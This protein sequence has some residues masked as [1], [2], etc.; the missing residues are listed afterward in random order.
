[1]ISIGEE[2]LQ[3]ILAENIRLKAQIDELQAASTAQLMRDRGNDRR[4]MVSAFHLKFNQPIADSPCVPDDKVVRLRLRLITEEFF[5][6]LSSCVMPSLEN[7]HSVPGGPLIAAWNDIEHAISHHEIS[8]NLPEFVD[9]LGDLDYVIEGTR[10]AFGVDGA[11]IAMEIQRANM[12]KEGGGERA[13]G[14]IQ[15]PPGW[16]PPDIARELRLQGWDSYR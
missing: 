4:K 2:E 5:E 13:D 15:K 3:R 14:K 11:P 10:L 12:S 7:T 6:L 16:T 9:A 8:V 1:M